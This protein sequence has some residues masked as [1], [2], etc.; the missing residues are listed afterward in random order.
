MEPHLNG[1]RATQRQGWA[2]VYGVGLATFSVVTS[3]M[4]PVGLMTA[5]ATSLG[6]SMGVAGLMIS[7]PAG[8]AA[9]FA[10][11][12]V[13]VVGSMDRR[14]IIAGLLALL[15]L[16]NLASALAPSI[17]WLLAARAI[18]GFCMG[19]IWAISGGLAPRLVQ[20]A[21]VA[22]ATAIIFGG[23]A[24]ASVLGVPLGAIIGDFAGW[25]TAFA[26][27]ALFSALVLVLNLYLLPSLP[28]SHAVSPSQ[29]GAQLARGPVLLG[30]A[31]TLLLVTGHFMAYTFVSPVL[32]SIAQVKPQWL[33]VLLFAYGAAGIAGNF[34][35]G[36]AAARYIKA[37]LLAISLGLVVAIAGFALLGTTPVSGTG[38]LVLW[39]VAYGG[40]SVSLQ[41]LMMKA[42]PQAVEV[43]TALFVSVFNIAIAAGSFFG[44]QVVDQTGLANNLLLAAALPV[45][46]LLFSLSLIRR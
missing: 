19:G 4:L 45:V 27:M 11:L 17:G 9:L 34:L 44:G 36:M 25:R 21:S 20:P 26:A 29:F 39:G 15:S 16:A 6:T 42:A 13:L 10:P 1:P 31:I 38:L 32:Q 5:I 41:T 37:T 12:V 28:I 2:S 30:L 43:A 24:A 8:L 7:V 35:A 33:G 3:E 14:L 22:A 23:V 18:V 40:V 46:A